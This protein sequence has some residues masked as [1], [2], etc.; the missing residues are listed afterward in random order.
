ML[1]RAQ[2][3]L[4]ARR[5]ALPGAAVALRASTEA[6]QVWLAEHKRD[7]SAWVMLS[8]TAE[9]IGLR[10][11]SLRANA[12]AR[13]AEGDLGGAIDRLRA[14]QQAA[15]GNA[16]ALDFI[17]ASIIDSRLREL[18]GQRRQLALDARG[19]SRQGRGEGDQP[20]Q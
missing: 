6:L 11:R 18:Q 13:A 15:R 8:S 9:A 20:P 4:D 10:L 14:A 7:V 16:G 12:E 19:N 5:Q 17:E 2:A 3:A 1:L